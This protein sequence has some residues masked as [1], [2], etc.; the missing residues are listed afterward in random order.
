MNLKWESEE[1]QKLVTV[2]VVGA[3]VLGG[4]AGCSS[5]K[6]TG[7]L[8]GA[9]TGAVLGGVL[10]KQAGNT[11]AGVI[12]GAAVGGAAGV[13]IGDYMDDQAEAL[14]DVDGAEIKRVGEGI[15]V[16]FDSGILFAVNKADLSSEAKI[17][18]KKMARVMADYPDTDVLIAGHTDSDGAEDYNQTLSENRANAVRNYLTREG[19]DANRLASLGYGESQ[20]VADNTTRD[21]KAMNRRVELAIVANEA[22]QERAASTEG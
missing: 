12:A 3:I 15:Q 20:P 17:N 6:K 10:G 13:I 2:L 19:V 16:T 1:M 9:T 8:I 22:L 18:I 5:S 7:G 21:G 14:A 11:T 4:A